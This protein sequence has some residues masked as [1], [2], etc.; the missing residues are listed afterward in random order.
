MRTEERIATECSQ[1]FG[2][3]WPQVAF[4]LLCLA[5]F[6]VAVKIAA[7]IW[8]AFQP[9]A[10]T[11]TTTVSGR[12]IYYASKFSVLLF[13]ATML[14]RACVEAS[15]SSH[16]AFWAVLLVVAVLMVIKVMRQRAAGEWYGYAHEIKQRWHR[17]RGQ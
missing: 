2:E 6:F 11:V 8:L 12:A 10:T 16:I 9:D 4:V 14:A 1:D 17:Q 3:G 7:T 5:G 15:P 13:L